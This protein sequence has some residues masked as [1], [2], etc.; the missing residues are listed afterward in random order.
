LVSHVTGRKQFR[1]VGEKVAEQ[2][3]NSK[4]GEEREREREAGRGSGAYDEIENLFSSSNVTVG[5]Q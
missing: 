1:G 3:F 5:N 4:R 2:I